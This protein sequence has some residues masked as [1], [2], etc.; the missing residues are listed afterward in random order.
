MKNT[1]YANMSDN[2][3]LKTRDLIRGVYIGFGIIYVLVLVVLGYLLVT[4]GLQ[5]I[6]FAVLIPV[7]T[8]PV[9]R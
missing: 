9:H 7:F 8:L 5:K 6:S 4:S 1:V 2:K 3:L